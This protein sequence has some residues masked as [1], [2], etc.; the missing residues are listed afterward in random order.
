MTEEETAK[1]LAQMMSVAESPE[2][3]PTGDVSLPH[4]QG[5]NCRQ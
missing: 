4:R 1:I 2:E 3:P 5:Q